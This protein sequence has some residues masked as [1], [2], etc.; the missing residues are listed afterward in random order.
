MTK[1]IIKRPSS[2]EDFYNIDMKI[3]RALRKEG[4]ALEELE[5]RADR[6]IGKLCSLEMRNLDR[7]HDFLYSPLMDRFMVFVTKTGNIGIIWFIVFCIML[8][9]DRNKADLYSYA[10]ALILCVIIGNILIKNLVKRSRPFFHKKYKLLIDRPWDYSFPSG[11]T[12]SSFAAATS[13]LLINSTVGVL[14]FVYAS[15]IALSRLYLRVHFF[16]DVLFS[17]V[18]GV[19]LGL[20][21]N[22][23]YVT[24]LFSIL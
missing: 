4:K 6:N 10:I 22:Y 18:L 24:Y 21:A 15:L 11:H 17:M 2:K 16:T 23:I 14:A 5:R 1:L 19:V 20:V 12:L 7:L 8:I 3:A 9:V 13:L